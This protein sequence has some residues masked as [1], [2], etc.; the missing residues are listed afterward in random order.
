MSLAAALEADGWAVLPRG[1]D[2]DPSK[3]PWGWAEAL[4]GRRPLLL[5][6]QPIRPIPGGRSFASRDGG[7]PLHTDS[8]ALLGVPAHLQVLLCARAAAAGGE[9]TLVDA[10]RL[11]ERLE[12]D[13][14][15]L[16]TAL[17]D[18]P[19]TLR[20]Y[21]GTFTGPT[22]SRRRGHVFFTHPPAPAPGDAVGA[23][24][25][26]AVERQ[27]RVVRRLETGEVL[28]VNNH[29][30]LHGRLPF[31]DP[32]RELVRLLIWLH[33]PPAAP[34]RIAG[35]A[36][37][38][39]PLPAPGPL[40]ARRRAVVQELLAGAPPGVLE[41]REGVREEELYRWRDAWFAAGA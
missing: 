10:W 33:E 39:P 8:Q 40:D 35:R 25:Q 4:L 5:E 23:R 17:F 36:R 28:V 11:V 34:P 31:Q 30:L 14:P 15:A 6:R 7:A 32:A 1:P 13:D 27:P 24:V 20:F 18:A 2:L 21:F 29:R 26:A 22:V 3:D 19:R 38:A 41:R 9:T 37:E 12:R 16:H